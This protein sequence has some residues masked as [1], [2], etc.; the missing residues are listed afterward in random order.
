[1]KKRNAILIVILLVFAVPIFAQEPNPVSDFRVRLNEA[2]DGVVITDYVGNSNTVIIPAQI[3]GY[4]V[5]ELGRACFFMKRVTSVIIP[6]TVKR[7]SYN[8]FSR[9]SITSIYLPASVELISA[10]AFSNCNNLRSVTIDNPRLRVELARDG[11]Y[12]YQEVFHRCSVLS[13]FILPEG[14]VEILPY[15]VREC[16]RLTA[17]NIPASVT[18]IGE[19]A[20]RQCGLTSVTLPSGVQKIGSFAFEGN[21]LTSITLPASISEIGAQAFSG[22]RLTEVIIPE[23]VSTI[24]F[25]LFDRRSRAFGLRTDNLTLS[26]QAALKRVGYPD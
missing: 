22:N 12:L 11:S 13:E 9:S 5:I 17:I 10:M 23:N 2:G 25:T 19:S 20:F 26:S 4:P 21:P 8:A 15:L 16:S 7:I 18:V 14:M 3:E 6:D 24:N 1:M